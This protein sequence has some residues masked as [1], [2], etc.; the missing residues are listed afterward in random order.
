MA[1]IYT[2]TEDK[3][4]K[5]AEEESFYANSSIGMADALWTMI[6]NQS[7]EVQTDLAW[8]LNNMLSSRNLLKREG[9]RLYHSQEAIL[10]R[11]DKLEEGIASGNTV[12]TSEEDLDLW[13]KNLD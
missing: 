13:I 12:W 5:V 2:E 1:R 6:C 7:E 3:V 4:S 11:M 8:R 10:K 9:Y